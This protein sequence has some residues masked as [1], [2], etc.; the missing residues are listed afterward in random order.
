MLVPGDKEAESAEDLMGICMTATGNEGRNKPTNE[1]YPSAPRMRK[2]R[3]KFVFLKP[4]TPNP[5]PHACEATRMVTWKNSRR[6]LDF[7][8]IRWVRK[9]KSIHPKTERYCMRRISLRQQISWAAHSNKENQRCACFT[10]EFRHLEGPG[11]SNWEGRKEGS[12]I[13]RSYRSYHVVFRGWMDKYK[14]FGRSRRCFDTT[15]CGS[16][17]ASRELTAA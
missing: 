3:N 1:K 10:V 7:H 8:F 5:I 14:S 17:M 13:P 2:A 12:F 16:Q 9:A 6:Y 4:R 11:D 15:I